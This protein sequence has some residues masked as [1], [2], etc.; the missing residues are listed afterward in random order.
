MW[1][2]VGGGRQLGADSKDLISLETYLD[3]LND[4]SVFCLDGAINLFD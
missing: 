1:L 2:A 4:P 3:L